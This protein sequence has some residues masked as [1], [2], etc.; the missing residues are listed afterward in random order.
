[1]DPPVLVDRRHIHVNNDDNGPGSPENSKDRCDAYKDGRGFAN[2][3]LVS[4]CFRLPPKP[5]NN[6]CV[7]EKE[8]GTWDEIND[9]AM[10]PL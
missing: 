8:D 5:Q 1:M 7:S 3:D 6:Y 4:L 9:K 10:D 2:A